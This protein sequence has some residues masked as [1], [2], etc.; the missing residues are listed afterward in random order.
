MFFNSIGGWCPRCHRCRE[1]NCDGQFPPL[2]SPSHP[3]TLTCWICQSPTMFVSNTLF[4]RTLNQRLSCVQGSNALPFS[5]GGAQLRRLN[6]YQ[7]FYMTIFLTTL[8]FTHLSISYFVKKKKNVLRIMESL[9]KGVEHIEPWWPT[10]ISSGTI[11]LNKNPGQ[12]GTRVNVKRL[13]SLSACDE[14]I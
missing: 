11:N 2:S 13:H 14:T 3:E 8:N 4:V 12:G 6:L 7:M 9:R 5:S 1:V 10:T